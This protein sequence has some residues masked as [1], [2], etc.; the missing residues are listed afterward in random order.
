MSG[1]YFSESEIDEIIGAV[2]ESM[3]KAAS[4]AKADFSDTEDKGDAPEMAAPPEMA[5]A[6]AAD[7]PPPAPAVDVAPP[8]PGM[9]AEESH[10]IGTEGE[11]M[12]GGEPAAEEG[13]EQAPDQ[14]EA[15]G[16]AAL[17]ED[18][19]EL[20]D[21]ELHQIYA[22]MDPSDLERHYMIIRGML[23]DAYA[24][25]E[26]SED[27]SSDASTKKDEVDMVKK[28]EYENKI[29]ELEKSNEEM[30]KSLEAAIKAVELI[31][32]PERKAVTSEVQV[33][34]KTESDVSSGKE[35]D[36]DYSSLSK[37][38]ITAELNKKVRDPN[39]SKSDR[40]IINGYLL[41]GEGQKEVIKLLG[42]K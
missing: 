29:S 39:L 26:K 40:D 17:A 9:G 30:K 24:K 2:E 12:P 7:A 18:D 14:M 6:S 33:L 31:S 11:E 37:S 8:A 5:D 15:E 16:D 3:Q 19:G 27:G 20:S 32:K 21:D 35:S 10:E 22:S 34:G 1:H 28:S 25:M 23:R 4:L 38:E 13:M 42:S 36:I 41:R